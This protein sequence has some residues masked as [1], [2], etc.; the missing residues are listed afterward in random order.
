MVRRTRGRNEQN[1]PHIW[2][3]E[4][5]VL[6]TNTFS[7]TVTTLVVF[8]IVLWGGFTH[9]CIRT[10]NSASVVLSVGYS[11]AFQLRMLSE[12]RASVV[13]YLP[14]K[15]PLQF[16]EFNDLPVCITEF[17][18]LFACFTSLCCPFS[19]FMF[20]PPSPHCVLPPLSH[21]ICPESTGHTHTH[22]HT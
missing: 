16:R 6:E 18:K 12:R 7:F 1:E 17:L 19:T 4:Y 3:S 9:T 13:H 22:T 20:S 2:C 5:C 21:C 14:Q 8:C 11:R 15:C 10:P